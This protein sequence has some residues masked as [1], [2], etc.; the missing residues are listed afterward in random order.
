MPRRLPR[1][2]LRGLVRAREHSLLVAGGR[3]QQRSL[4]R[5][6]SR[7]RASAGCCCGGC[8]AMISLPVPDSFHSTGLSSME[9]LVAS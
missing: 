4:R 6:S 5:R 9:V 8:S 2:I 1:N 3:L 7:K